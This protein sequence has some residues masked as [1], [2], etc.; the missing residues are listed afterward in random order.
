MKPIIKF[1]WLGLLLAPLFV[2]FAYS[3]IFASLLSGGNPLFS[4]LFFFA[5]GS[6]FSYATTVFLFL[7]CLYFTARFTRPTIGLACIF[8]A[9]LGAVAYLPLAWMMFQT[10]GVD[11]GPPQ[12]TFAEALGRDVRDPFVWAF[13]IGGLITATIYWLFARQRARRDDRTTA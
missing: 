5:F 7:P 13:P 10:S 6:C 3:A 8:G 9:V 2:P 1:S 4:F 11:S 12:G